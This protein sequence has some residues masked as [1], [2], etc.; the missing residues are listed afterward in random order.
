MR[1]I[2]RNC[3]IL[4]VAVLI[5]GLFASCNSDVLKEETTEQTVLSGGDMVVETASSEE[6]GSV[7]EMFVPSDNS[8]GSAKENT[9]SPMPEETSPNPTGGESNQQAYR[10]ENFSCE[11]STGTIFGKIYIPIQLSGTAPAV[12]LS[13]SYMLKYTSLTSY[14]E[15]MAESGYIA[16]CFNFNTNNMT[17]FTEV[18]DLEAVIAAVS[19]RS[20]VNKNKIFLFGTSLGG[21]VSALTANSHP[22]Q[23]EG[24]ILLYPALIDRKQAQEWANN[25]FVSSSPWVKDLVNYEVFDHIANF[26]GDVLI[27]HGTNDQMINIEFSRRAAATYAHATLI[28]IQGANHGFNKYQVPENMQPLIGAFFGDF[29]AQVNPYIFNFLKSHI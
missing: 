5:C 19:A 17:V 1:S 12:I 16:C 20:D 23:I 28:P 14:A 2:K 26:T 21:L 11:S 22:N 18:S 9:I 24:L 29:D 6:T 15:Q 4:L 10:V 7:P 27:I 3:S 25:V 8:S 13:H